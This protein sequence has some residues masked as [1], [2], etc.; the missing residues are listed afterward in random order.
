MILIFA[1]GVYALDEH[2]FIP[3]HTDDTFSTLSA[4]TLGKSKASI[5]L[6]AE[7]VVEPDLTRISLSME[8]GLGDR[9]DILL[10]LPFVTGYGGEEG[11]QDIGVAI[12]YRLLAERLISPAVS[13][14][15]GFTYPGDNGISTRGSGGGGIAVS[16]KVGPLSGNLNLLYFEPAESGLE[17][18]I[19]VNLGASLAVAHGFKAIGDL[20][21]VK[22]HYSE[23]IDRIEGRIG[24][25]VSLSEALTGS[26]GVGYD[27]KN[28]E[29]E[30]RFF[31]SFSLH[32]PEK[33]REI[34][35]IYEED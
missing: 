25:R 29:P 11:F 32:Y 8:Y 24:Y 10:H 27:F 15:V 19:E 13:V 20:V 3:T 22:S 16:K 23:R 17:E 7:K 4:Y 12:K 1:K 28:R 21:F 2:K 33:K 26:V 34:R 18:E 14:I 31:L 5:T 9:T 30:W 6:W 35:R